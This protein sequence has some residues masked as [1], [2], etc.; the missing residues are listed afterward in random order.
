MCLPHDKPVDLWALKDPPK[1][2]KPGLPYPG[3]IKLAIFSSPKQK[4]T[5]QEIYAALMERFDYFR[6]RKSEV[7]WKVRRQ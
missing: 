2:E 3:L 4:L 1:G 6:D 7:A 5:L